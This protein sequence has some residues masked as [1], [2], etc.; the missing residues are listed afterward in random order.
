MIFICQAPLQLKQEITNFG[1]LEH[2]STHR[3][4]KR[5][6]QTLV[7]TAVAFMTENNFQ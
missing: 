7:L 3:E 2:I 1:T 6:L 4:Q 5:L